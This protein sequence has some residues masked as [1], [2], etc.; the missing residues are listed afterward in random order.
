[1]RMILGFQKFKFGL[2]LVDFYFF[3]LK[4]LLDKTLE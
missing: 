1:M 2:Q 4:A 3:S